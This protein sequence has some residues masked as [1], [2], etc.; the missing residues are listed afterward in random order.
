MELFSQGW[1]YKEIGAKVGVSRHR[2]YRILCR[3]RD[4]WATSTHNEKRCRDE[5]N[6]RVIELIDLGI[7]IN[8]VAL[9]M[10]LSTTSVRSI[11]RDNIGS[12]IDVKKY[13]TDTIK[14]LLLEGADVHRIVKEA[15]GITLS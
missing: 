5:R 3:Y 1:T 7:A 11:M 15:Y 8:E 6:N 4:K 14:R 13:R 10:R 12:S 2:I 9:I